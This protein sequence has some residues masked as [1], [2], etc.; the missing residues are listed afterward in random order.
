MSLTVF[1]G[2]PVPLNSGVRCFVTRTTRLVVFA[3]ALLAALQAYAALEL[4][5][6][7]PLFGD[8]PMLGN[9][10]S[11]VAGHLRELSQQHPDGFKYIPGIDRTFL[12]FFNRHG[13]GVLLSLVAGLAFAFS[14]ATDI[15][16]AVLLFRGSRA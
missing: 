1:S 11:R 9:G 12:W 3:L 13:E 15:L 5:W 8:P 6:S 4:T 16:F 2:G 7:V 10:A 14:A